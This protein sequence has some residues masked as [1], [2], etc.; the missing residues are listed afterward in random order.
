MSKLN[1]WSLD[2]IVI[3]LAI[4]LFFSTSTSPVKKLVVPSPIPILKINKR[5]QGVDIFN[6]ILHQS[7]YM[8]IDNKS[9]KAKVYERKRLNGQSFYPSE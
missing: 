6:P 5:Y 7:G 3:N 2:L 9:N 8:I 4:F 1:S